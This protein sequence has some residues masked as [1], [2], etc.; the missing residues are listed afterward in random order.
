MTST[1]FSI[2]IDPWWQPLM[3]PGGALPGSSYVELDDESLKIRLGFLFDHTIPRGQIES[4]AAYNWPWWMGI[5]WRSNLRD[6]FGLIGS[7]QGVVE[8]K[9]RSPMRVWRVLN[10]TRIAVSLDD[11]EQFLATLGA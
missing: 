9:L 3:W 1:K 2:K 8:I 6:Q 10:C 7:Y 11:S 4:A 5:G